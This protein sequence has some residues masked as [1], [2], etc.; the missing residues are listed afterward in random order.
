MKLAIIFNAGGLG[1][2][3]MTFPLFFSLKEFFNSKNLTIDI[4]THLPS[5]YQ[6]FEKELPITIVKVSDL[7]YSSPFK[8]YFLLRKRRYDYLINLVIGR[9]ALIHTFIIRS[10]RKIFYI[11]INKKRINILFPFLKNY[12]CNEPSFYKYKKITEAFLERKVLWQYPLLKCSPSHYNFNKVKLTL[13]KHNNIVFINPFVKETLRKVPME[14]FINLIKILRKKNFYP[15]LIGGKDAIPLSQKIAKN[16]EVTNLVGKFSIQEFI[17]ILNLGYAFITPDSGPLHL[18]LL[19][20]IKKVIPI[21]T[22]VKP[23][24]RIPAHYINNKVFPIFLY[25]ELI[26]KREFISSCWTEKDQKVASKF[27]S[28]L[29]QAVI[30]QPTLLIDKILEYLEY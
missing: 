13:L 9:K 17:C 19:S 27:Y 4:Y 20:N 11:S 21:F 2:A 7:Y 14:F 6:L 29:V 8:D 16:V 15:V 22:F 18:S 24:W 12:S 23:I 5:L 3:T 1:D 28:E 10:K 25:E 30:K 26:K